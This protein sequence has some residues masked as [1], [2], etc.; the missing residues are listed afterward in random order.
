V[1][2]SHANPG[3]LRKTLG[4]LMYQTVKPDETIVLLSSTP[5]AEIQ[6]LREDFPHAT[7]HVREDRSD[8]GHEKRA[9]GLRL[10][11]SDFLGFFNDDD[12]YDLTYVEKMLAAVDGYDAAYCAWNTIPNCSFRLCS[13]TSG[14]FIVRTSLAKALG[15]PAERDSEGRLKYES[16]GLFINAIAANGAV[17]PKVNEILYHHNAQ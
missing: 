7:F 10:A 13:S 17:A 14:N 8:W 6:E 1:V 16:D 12:S 15:Y 2:V 3:G 9:E 11:S 4:N 5:S